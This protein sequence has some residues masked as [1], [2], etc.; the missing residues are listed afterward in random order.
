M[1]FLIYLGMCYNLIANLAVL[2]L[3]GV[4]CG[5]RKGE[6]SFK[7]YMS[8]QCLDNLGNLQLVTGI[9]NFLGDIYLLVL[10]I[11]SVL[12]L[13]FPRK[14]KVATCAVFMTGLGYDDSG[15]SYTGD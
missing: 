11:P 1:R 2:I 14:K 13:Q 7:H 3:S 10:P 5:P 4:L 8:A 12:K 9:V 15:R 6:G